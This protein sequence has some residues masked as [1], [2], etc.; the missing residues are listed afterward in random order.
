MNIFNREKQQIQ[1]G[2]NMD[3]SYNNN[4]V[5]TPLL[6]S[7]AKSNQFKNKKNKPNI[8]NTPS[9]PYWREGKSR[10]IKSKNLIINPAFAKI[11]NYLKLIINK[12]KKLEVVNALQN[13]QSNHSDPFPPLPFGCEAREG[14]ME[15]GASQNINQIIP[16]ENQVLTNLFTDWRSAYEELN[17]LI[18]RRTGVSDS[19]NQSTSLLKVKSD[20]GIR[21]IDLS[22]IESLPENDNATKLFKQI[23]KSINEK[24]KIKELRK[25]QFKKQLELRNYLKS[26]YTFKPDLAFNQNIVYKYAP[27]L[28]ALRGAPTVEGGMHTI[29]HRK[30]AAQMEEQ[31]LNSSHSGESRMPSSA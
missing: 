13:N 31:R 4:S 22:H 11:T 27:T 1:G 15:R 7:L 2:S 23:A 28:P 21:R 9:H 29:T 5:V 25:S 8:K 10:I 17:S 18:A 19:V 30:T 6:Y 20:K 12:E 16:K 3:I 14:G 26:L 24:N